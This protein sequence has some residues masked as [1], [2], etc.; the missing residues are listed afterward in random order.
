M[1]RMIVLLCA[2]ALAAC[3]A[4]KKLTRAED[5]LRLYA[6]QIRWNMF[7]G[8]ATLIDVGKHPEV[9]PAP[10]KNFKVVSYIPVRRVDEED[11]NTILQT[12]RIGYYD[13]RTARRSEV[14]D[15][16]VWRYD[17]ETK[18]W[19]LDGALPPFK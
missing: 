6:Q 2:L 17:D 18:R 13:D 9:D 19:R 14:M 16:Q 7:D 11:G 5:T 1:K 3:A 8:A 15:H 4:D 12:V 10:L